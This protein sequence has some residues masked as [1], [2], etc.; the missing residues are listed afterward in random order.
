[1]AKPRLPRASAPETPQAVTPLPAP[2]SLDELPGQTNLTRVIERKLLK[3]MNLLAALACCD[4][5]RTNVDNLT[6][7]I[8][9]VND[10]LGDVDDDLDQLR[11]ALEPKEAA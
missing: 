3:V 2:L 6:M 1:M 7:S 4:A 9:V 10:L 8:E 11:D 5:E